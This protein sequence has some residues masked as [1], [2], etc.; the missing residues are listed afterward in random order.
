MKVKNNQKR[1]G[2]NKKVQNNQNRF[3]INRRSI[4]KNFTLTSMTKR[5]NLPLSESCSLLIVIYKWTSINILPI[6]WLIWIRSKAG[7]HMQRLTTVQP[8]LLATLTSIWHQMQ[9]WSQKVEP[10][11][12]AHMHIS[13]FKI[14]AK[15]RTW[16]TQLCRSL[17]SLERRQSII[18]FMPIK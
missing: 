18:L 14:K 4:N 7:S 13:P 17:T 2:I 11:I 9:C 12:K 8:F 15:W 10:W 16:L 1:Y 3:E 6:T 5:V